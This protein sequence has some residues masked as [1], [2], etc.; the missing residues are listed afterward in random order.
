MLLMPGREAPAMTLAELAVE[1]PV[2]R[3]RMTRLGNLTGMPARVPPRGFA[4]G[5]P[6]LPL[7]L[8]VMTRRFDE[9]VIDQIAAAGEASEPWA[10]LHPA[11]LV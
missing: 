4:D 1:S 5:P 3:G 6:R 9:P 11:C 7:S 10:S 2:A 8:Q